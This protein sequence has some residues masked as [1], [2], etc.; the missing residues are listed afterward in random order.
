MTISM[1]LLLITLVRTLQSL[2]GYIISEGPLTTILAACTTVIVGPLP[3]IYRALVLPALRIVS[4]TRHELLP[5]LGGKEDSTTEDASAV[6]WH[7]RD[8]GRELGAS[9]TPGTEVDL[10]LDESGRCVR[11]TA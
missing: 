4:F 6:V 7:D 10:H 8:G 5:Y 2:L 3:T 11:R 1:V 9:G